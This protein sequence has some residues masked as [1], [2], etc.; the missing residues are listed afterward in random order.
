MFCYSCSMQAP[1]GLRVSMLNKEQIF[2]WKMR[3]QKSNGGVLFSSFLFLNISVMS[4]V[5]LCLSSKLNYHVDRPISNCTSH[6]H[7]LYMYTNATQRH[8]LVAQ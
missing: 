7:T 1:D 2:V 6:T 5:S 8:S 4:A 3:H